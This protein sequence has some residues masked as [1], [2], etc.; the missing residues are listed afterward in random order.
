MATQSATT[1]TTH[2]TGA[3]ASYTASPEEAPPP[4]PRQCRLAR[5]RAVGPRRSCGRRTR[6][7][8]TTSTITTS[9]CRTRHR[10][11]RSSRH[12]RAIRGSRARRRTRSS[13]ACA[14]RSSCARCAA[15]RPPSPTAARPPTRGWTTGSAR[16]TCAAPAR[17]RSSA[18]RTTSDATGPSAE[19]VGLKPTAGEPHGRTRR[20]AWLPPVVR[21]CRARRVA[22]TPLYCNV[23]RPRATG[24]RMPP[25][26]RRHPEP[27]ARLTRAGLVWEQSSGWL[28]RE[29]KGLGVGHP[30]RATAT[31]LCACAGSLNHARMARA[32][33][34]PHVARTGRWA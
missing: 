19:T 1:A 11:R 10:T 30:S 18:S 2:T 32:R 9:C 16:C 5:H 24:G 26:P 15:G 27:P 17:P 6:R 21:G 23:G 33:T 13:T 3:T 4:R 34:C 25:P 29:E 22:A 14:T 12:P 31:S 7:S 28:R 8:A 20:D